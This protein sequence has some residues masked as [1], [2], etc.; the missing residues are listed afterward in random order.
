MPRSHHRL[1]NRSLRIATVA[2]AAGVVVNGLRL[3]GRAAELLALPLAPSGAA[4]DHGPVGEDWICISATGVELD[5]RTWST[6]VAWA[7]AQGL[8]AV[9]L[10][11]ADLTVERTLDVLRQVDPATYRADPLG[12]GRTAGHAILVRTRVAE[13]ADP[14]PGPVAPAELIEVARQVKRFAPRTTDCVVAPHERAVDMTDDER[15]AVRRTV[16]D[17]YA[18]VADVALTAELAVLGLG[19]CGAP[20]VGLPA[21]AAYLTQPALILGGNPAG[22]KPRDR[23]VLTPL[24]W[25][26]GIRQL[27]AQRGASAPEAASIRMGEELRPRYQDEL[28]LGVDRFFEPRV[29][30][31]PWCAATDLTVRLTSP[32]LIQH[33]PGT[34]ELDECRACGH[35]FQNPRLTIEGLD[36]YYRDFYDGF[37]GDEMERIFAAESSQYDGRAEMVAA[38]NP[39]PARWLDVGTGHAHF[40]LV[41]KGLFPETSFEGVDLN[42]AVEDAAHRGWV[43]QAYRG[44]FPDLAPELAGRFDVVSMH[45]YIEHTRDPKAE[46][47]AAAVAIAPGGLLLIE[48]PDPDCAW[49]RFIGNRWMPWFQPQHQHFVS[50]DRLEAALEERGFTLLGRYRSPSNQALDLIAGLWLSLGQIVPRPGMPWQPRPTVAMRIRRSLVCTAAAPLVVVIMVINQIV[51]AFA[52][53][54][55]AGNAFRVLARYD[56]VSIDQPVDQSA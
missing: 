7:D 31:C 15:L 8:D 13:R 36:F 3:R 54:D 9:D 56:G 25:F 12:E 19:A 6:A 40:C 39:S 16:F 43:D 17:R 42:S 35:I 50:I 20:S 53:A 34:F 55:G 5:P 23:G 52:D 37:A 18:T 11:P 28:A 45:H 32:D 46:L 4:V 48:L 24:R 38:E 30:A 27:V 1:A 47:D 51:K 26:N 21:L 49:G 14:P 29:G 41:A 33:K 2:T 44:L 22:L 10:I